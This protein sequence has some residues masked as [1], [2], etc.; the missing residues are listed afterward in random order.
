MNKLFYTT[1]EISSR[2]GLPIKTIRRLAHEGR[3]RAYKPT[4]KMYLFDLDEISEDIK[5]YETR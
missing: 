1:K 4:Q 3:I 2:T 5:K